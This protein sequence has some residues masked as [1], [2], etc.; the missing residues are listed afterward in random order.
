M[1]AN[2]LVPTDGTEFCTRAVRHAVDLARAS[3]GR[4]TAVTVSTPM[5]ASIKAQLTPEVRDAFEAQKAAHVKAALATVEVAAKASGVACERV[6]IDDE[7]VYNGI[8]TV[9]RDRGCDLI[10]MAS[11]GRRGLGAIVIGSETQKVVVH[12]TIPVL[13]YR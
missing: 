8:L 7:H 6:A 1:F 3:G 2:I 10:V 4:I 12:S 13:V 11:H 9:A 5:L